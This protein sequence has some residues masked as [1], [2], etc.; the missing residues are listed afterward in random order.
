MMRSRSAR[1]ASSD[2][3]CVGAERGS[4]AA[5]APGRASGEIRR[6][7]GRPGFA[8]AA[9]ARFSVTFP[10]DLAAADLDGVPSKPRYSFVSSD[11]AKLE[12]WLRFFHS[13]RVWLLGIIP[14]LI[15]LL[16]SVLP[17]GLLP[18]IVVL[19]LAT[20][21]AGAAFFFGGAIAFTYMTHNFRTA[22]EADR[23]KMLW[24]LAGGVAS[25]AVL[26]IVS[27]LQMIAD[28]MDMANADEWLLVAAPAAVL[29]FVLG[30][31]AAVFLAGAVDPRLA[32]RRTTVSAIVA[33]LA[34]F[35][36]AGLETLV[37]DML[38][39]RMGFSPR[40]GSWVAG[41]TVA[42]GL[43]PLHKVVRTRLVPLRR[44]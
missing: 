31:A 6:E 13:P 3:G 14:A 2:S 11:R 39:A 27:I 18:E 12:M 37:A 35:A 4:A 16:I 32:I 19:V 9:F 28:H 17:D 41:V 40:I 10:R 24:I 8:A 43:Q 44:Q 20:T 38:A 26:S 33:G 21:Y 29:V 42:L 22:G 36:F 30:I 34:I 15:A 7:R 25:I 1:I 5:I 23:R